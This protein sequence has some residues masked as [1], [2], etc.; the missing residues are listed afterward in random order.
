M[1]I[2]DTLPLTSP[3]SSTGDDLP[4]YSPPQQFQAALLN[5]AND[6]KHAKQSYGTGAR[7]TDYWDWDDDNKVY[8][9]QQ[10][11]GEHVSAATVA[12]AAAGGTATTRDAVHRSTDSRNGELTR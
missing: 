6:S 12:A 7:A 4:I 3:P 10:N 2:D 5:T 8:S 1:I 11:D 9:I